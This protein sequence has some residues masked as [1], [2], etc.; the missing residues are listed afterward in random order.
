MTKTH[1]KTTSVVTTSTP[2]KLA[3]DDKQMLKH[4]ANKLV[5]EGRTAA[6]SVLDKDEAKHRSVL[7]KQIAAIIK[8]V[9]PQKDMAVLAKYD[10]AQAL[11]GTRETLEI[12]CVK[13]G[14]G[15][16]SLDIDVT[17]SPWNQMPELKDL[18]IPHGSD[19]YGQLT[20]PV[21]F[22][23]Q[24]K[25]YNTLTG[26]GVWVMDT[27]A[28]LDIASRRADI[29]EEFSRRE[30]AYF[31]LI[32][33]AKTLEQVAEVWPEVKALASRMRGEAPISLVPADARE[34]IMR[35]V[36]ERARMA[37]LPAPKKS[38]A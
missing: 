15:T 31:T 34:I 33:Q 11:H 4:L 26:P 1:T 19:N 24:W 10:L 28:L 14:S 7:A 8:L 22:Q 36:A 2:L 38:A 20:L 37:A 17:G 27:Q 29:E 12:E 30:R 3:R 6:L 21:N 23:M 5:G 13:P 16:I 35:D 32:D 25:D 9:F 18:L